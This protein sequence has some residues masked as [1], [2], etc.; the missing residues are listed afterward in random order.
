[1]ILIHD[2]V[3]HSYIYGLP[4]VTA[5]VYLSIMCAGFNVGHLWCMGTLLW[6]MCETRHPA[7][8]ILMDL[9][10]LTLVWLTRGKR[11]VTLRRTAVVHC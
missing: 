11:P 7:W 3:L 4:L 8:Q 5:Y 10:M 6:I 9:V 1:M 2:Y